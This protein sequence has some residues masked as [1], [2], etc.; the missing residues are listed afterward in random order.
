MTIVRI[1]DGIAQYSYTQSMRTFSVKY[2]SYAKI[3]LLTQRNFKSK[4]SLALYELCVDFSG[5]A[6]FY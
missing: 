6:G 2:R 5:R 4:Y 3:N 1:V